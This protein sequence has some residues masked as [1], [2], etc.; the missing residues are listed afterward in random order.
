[1]NTAFEQRQYKA[2]S[3]K[4]A[5]FYLEKAGMAPLPLIPTPI[6]HVKQ[7]RW[8]RL[9]KPYIAAEDTVAN[10]ATGGHE[11]EEWSEDGPLADIQ[12]GFNDYHLGSISMYLST[13]KANIPQFVAGNMLADKR[14]AK[15]EKFALDVDEGLIRGIYDR[16]G[17]VKIVS[18][19][20]DQA[21]TVSNLNGVDSNLETKGDIWKAIVKMMETIPLGM[22]QSSPPME[23]VISEHLLAMATEPDRIYLQEIEWDYI[24]KYLMGANAEEARKINPIVKISNK[25]L[26]AGTDTIVTN[27][28]MALYVPNDRWIGKVVSRS[29]GLLGELQKMHTVIQHWGWTGRCIIDNALAATFSEPIVW[30]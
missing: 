5:K 30:I 25:L 17:K 23:L 20:Q 6:K 16:T 3:A 4:A 24:K 29:F 18:G 21:T 14:K 27:D 7:F 13:K 28:R 26:V 12:H 1:Y 9:E 15:I 8:T 10:V 22:R 11:A 19:Y 2:I